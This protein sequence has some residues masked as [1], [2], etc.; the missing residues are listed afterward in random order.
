MRYA[1][2]ASERGDHNAARRH[3]GATASNSGS[4]AAPVRD[5]S[6]L[7]RGRDVVH[8]VTCLTGREH[9]NPVESARTREGYPSR[10]PQRAGPIAM[11]GVHDVRLHDVRTPIGRHEPGDGLAVDDHE[12]ALP[13]R[14]CVQP[15]G[16][17]VP[18]PIPGSSRLPLLVVEDEEPARWAVVVTIGK[19][20][21]A[22]FAKVIH[23]ADAARGIPSHPRDDE[24][25]PGA[26]LVVLVRLDG[27]DQGALHRGRGREERMSTKPVVEVDDAD[28]VGD[29]AAFAELTL[30]DRVVG[31][32][33]EGQ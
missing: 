14:Q 33:V 8:E 10:R 2:A 21:R 22:V 19:N 1:L 5:D 9:H 7:G 27:R 32:T 29:H 15:V 30:D 28:S 12:A 6:N 20:P 13:R 23:L 26:C 3:A 16:I 31:A 17:Q 25:I 18:R 11:R 4:L 24:A